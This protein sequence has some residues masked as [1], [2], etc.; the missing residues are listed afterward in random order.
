MNPLFKQIKKFWKKLLFSDYIQI[1]FTIFKKSHDSTTLY[2]LRKQRKTSRR[3]WWHE[4]QDFNLIISLIYICICI[5]PKKWKY[6]IHSNNK[7]ICR[8]ADLREQWN[9][10]LGISRRLLYY[11]NDND[12]DS[13]LLKTCTLIHK[14]ISL[15]YSNSVDKISTTRVP[16]H[17]LILRS[18]SFF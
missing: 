12:C 1:F 14:V 7:T 15:F 8:S 18:S 11:I 5:V 17:T 3:M 9:V 13:S 16:R 10:L 2:Y 4:D 6:C